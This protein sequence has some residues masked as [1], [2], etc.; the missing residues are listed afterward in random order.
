MEPSYP[1]KE[2]TEL[3]RVTPT[4]HLKNGFFCLACAAKKATTDGADGEAAPAPTE[5]GLGE[6]GDLKKSKFSESDG[7]T[8]EQ[9]DNLRNVSLPRHLS[10]RELTYGSFVHRPVKYP[11]IGRIH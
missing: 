2:S 8:P 7:L 10:L 11:L 3:F 1:P 5:P 6:T 4:A 9:R